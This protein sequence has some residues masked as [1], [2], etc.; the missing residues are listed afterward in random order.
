M[1]DA[2]SAVATSSRVSRNNQR[3]LDAA[4]TAAADEGWTGLTFVG[5]AERAGLSRRPLQDRYPDA[6][7]MMAAVWRERCEPALSAVFERTLAASGIY[8][9]GSDQE[10]THELDSVIHPD[11]TLRAAA[12]L[13]MIAQFD[14]L[15]REAVVS[16]LG[17]KVAAWCASSDAGDSDSGVRAAQNAYVISL[18][19]GLLIFGRRSAA[20]SL[21]F[22]EPFAVLHRA[23]RSPSSPVQLP[24]DDFSHLDRPVPFDTGDATTDALLQ[25]T[26][27]AVG[28]DGFD[29]MSVDRIAV[30]AGSSQGALFARYPSKLSL[31][32]DATRRQNAV[33][34]RANAAAMGGLEALYGGGVAEA[35]AIRE[36]QRPFRAHLRAITLEGIRV[37]WHDEDLRQAVIQELAD[38]ELEVAANGTAVYGSGSW[39]HFAFA[40]GAGVLILPILHRECWQL[41]YDVVTA[42]ILAMSADA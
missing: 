33:A 27:D 36:F 25:S 19:L 21:D 3:L 29:R 40:I 30:A 8:Q 42:P 17:A 15:V 11:E 13:L 9:T 12:E 39:F 14:K 34:V 38:Y 16:T 35:V 4:V 2:V 10:L 26:L 24:L 32:I 5:V 22:S 31:F 28:S 1:S 41:P 23:L 37:A 20:S 6:S 18:A 7:H